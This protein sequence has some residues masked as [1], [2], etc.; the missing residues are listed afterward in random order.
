[1]KRTIKR[2]VIC[3]LTVT[4]L[5]G[6]TACNK[7]EF[8]DSAFF[9]EADALA[10]QMQDAAT[11]VIDARTPEDYYKGHLEGAI[12]L[13]PALLSVQEPFPGL[14]APAEQ[15]QN[16]LG[17][18]GI[19]N[20]TR[21]FVYDNNGGVYA[22]RVW[23]VLR[24]YGHEAVSV[25]N[26]G[27]TAI[28]KAGLPLSTVIPAPEAKTYVAGGPNASMIATMDEVK[29]ATEGMSTVKLL[30]VR[31]QAE[32]DEGAIPGAILYPH[33]KNLY[34]DGTFRS[35][36]DTRLNYAD[37]GLKPDDAIIAYC[38]TSFR[39]AQTAIVLAEAGF[40]NVKVYDGAWVEWSA[41]DM[42]KEEAPAAS[43]APT[44]Q[45]AS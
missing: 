22:G 13:P 28:V 23:W 1:M 12:N 7:T 38:K 11:V 34:T 9:I 8:T 19:G 30:D 17:Q 10:A 21:V 43:T 24:Y 3:L 32:Y 29:A 37:L 4:L 35:G 45:D 16:V 36:R 31:T 18:H 5:L 20:D 42:P 27:E 2:A 15:V 6:L 25:V 39:A 41:G 33:T 14:V 44:V 40:T 26:G